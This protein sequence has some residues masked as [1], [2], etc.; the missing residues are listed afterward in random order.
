MEGAAA[1]FVVSKAY[2]EIAKL[3]TPSCKANFDCK[4][5]F[6]AVS[7]ASIYHSMVCTHYPSPLINNCMADQETRT[8]KKVLQVIDGQ[9]VLP[10]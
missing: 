7:N 1:S 10:S 6:R 2:K 4:S 9:Q 8:G 3:Q 5:E